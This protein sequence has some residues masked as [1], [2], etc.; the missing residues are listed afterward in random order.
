MRFVSKR[1]LW[2]EIQKL[3][4]LKHF[5][6]PHNALP[7]NVSHEF[8]LFCVDPQTKFGLFHSGKIN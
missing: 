7:E 5:T 8:L 2:R 6:I 4:F 1:G 3:V